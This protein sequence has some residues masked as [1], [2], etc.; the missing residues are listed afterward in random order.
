LPLAA[1][2]GPPAAQHADEHDPGLSLS[3]Q[4]ARDS[5][6]LLARYDAT[7]AAHPPLAALLAPLRAQ[8]A[9]HVEAF[10][11]PGDAG[12]TASPSAS[13]SVS[14]GAAVRAAARQVPSDRGQALAALAAAEQRLA[15]TRTAALQAAPPGLARLLASVAAADACHALLLQ[16]GA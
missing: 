9:Q 1:C 3:A 8:V 10:T 4:A 5:S 16:D 2:G 6:G 7:A 12:P 15:E 14:A 13:D 11:F